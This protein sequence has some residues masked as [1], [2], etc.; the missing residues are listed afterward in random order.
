MGSL[1]TPSSLA[2]KLF[3]S[4]CSVAL[5]YVDMSHRA[6]LDGRALNKVTH[7]L[8]NGPHCIP[9]LRGSIHGYSDLALLLSV[10]VILGKSFDLP[11]P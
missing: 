3:S 11:V 7:V 8:S 6:D 2:A 5:L 4:N 10:R 9:P 1:L